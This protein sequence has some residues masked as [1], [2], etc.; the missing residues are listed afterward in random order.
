MHWEFKTKKAGSLKTGSPLLSELLK[1]THDRIWF[2]RTTF[3]AAAVEV[4]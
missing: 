2:R 4:R 1:M 3:Q